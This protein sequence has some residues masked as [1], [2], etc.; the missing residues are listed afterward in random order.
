LREVCGVELPLRAFFAA[1]TVA[2]VARTI[3]TLRRH[4]PIDMSTIADYIDRLSRLSDEEAAILLEQV[5]CSSNS[6]RYDA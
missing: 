6:F 2:G 1:P 5:D 3:E 4:P